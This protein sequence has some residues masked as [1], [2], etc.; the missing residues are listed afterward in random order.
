M[1][2]NNEIL[3]RM[4]YIKSGLDNLNQNLKNFEEE[5]KYA[6]QVENEI[7]TYKS[8]NSE[9]NKQKCEENKNGT[10]NMINTGEIY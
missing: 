1:I 7:N 10:Q 5:L 2:E 8:D 3:N 9:N 6:K 4:N